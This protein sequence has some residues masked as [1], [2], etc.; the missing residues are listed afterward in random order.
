MK[1]NKYSTTVAIINLCLATCLTTANAQ[2]LKQQI[3]PIKIDG[4]E[5]R[6]I[7]KA[8]LHMNI[9]KNA[10]CGQGS[11]VSY[12]FLPKVDNPSFKTF[13]N[14]RKRIAYILRQR[15]PAGTSFEFSNPKLRKNSFATVFS[16]LRKTTN[17]NGQV[18][19]T[20]S[21][22][23]HTPIN[24]VSMISSSTNRKNVTANRATFGVAIT[25]MIRASIDPK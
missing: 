4:F 18:L 13:S 25:K 21:S 7:A 2:S 11:K 5:Y 1:F 12:I 3:M 14:D 19:F 6:Y 22:V 9:C 24:S 17:S 23:I 8:K 20:M 15:A 10:Q 16:Q